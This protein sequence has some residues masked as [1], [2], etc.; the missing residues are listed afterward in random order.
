LVGDG[1]LQKQGG[2]W[3]STC[4]AATRAR[5]ATG[6]Q[7]SV[8][9]PNTR[10]GR[11]SVCRNANA[12]ISLTRFLDAFR[13][14]KSNSRSRFALILSVRSFA[15]FLAEVALDFRVRESLPTE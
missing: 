5:L 2:S 14:Q 4:A 10:A 3:Q 12:R 7:G 8:S 13:P 15:L 1:P 9:A 6:S 11:R